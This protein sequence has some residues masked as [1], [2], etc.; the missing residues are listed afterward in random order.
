MALGDACF[1]LAV[2]HGERFHVHEFHDRVR[3]DKA[4]K[5]REAA[6]VRVP[7]RAR[8]FACVCARTHVCV[9]RCLCARARVC[10]CICVRARE[11]VGA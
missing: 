5:H 7:A 11:R 9:G 2:H 10:A 4:R 8:V 3:S 1:I 6:I